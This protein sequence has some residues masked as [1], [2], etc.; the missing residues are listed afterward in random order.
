MPKSYSGD[1]AS[2]GI[3]G[4]AE[5]LTDPFTSLLGPHMFYAPENGA[6]VGMTSP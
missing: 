4:P 6:S 1:D 5:R 2:K 3:A